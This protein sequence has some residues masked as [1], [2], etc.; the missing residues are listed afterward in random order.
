M[1][2]DD[3]DNL[4]RLQLKTADGPRQA[5]SAT[6]VPRS[7]VTLATAPAP[8]RLGVRFG[9]ELPVGCR[10]KHVAGNLAVG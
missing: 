4:T 3:S 2:T 10:I 9:L 6:F 7:G 1:K 8:V 5:R